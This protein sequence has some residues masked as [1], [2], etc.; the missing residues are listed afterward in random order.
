MGPLRDA[1]RWKR[2]EAVDHGR[3]PRGRVRHL[4]AE[5]VQLISVAAAAPSVIT[6]R[7]DAQGRRAY[8]EPTREGGGPLA[9]DLTISVEDR[10]GELARIGEA[11][12]NAGIN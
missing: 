3:P 5:D 1:P 10:P 7:F 6:A 12:G 4:M 11:L 2:R 9:T 8:A